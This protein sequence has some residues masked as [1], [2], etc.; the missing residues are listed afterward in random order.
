M[1]GHPLRER[2][3]R[4]LMLALYPQ[5]RHAE[6]LAAFQE[7]RAVLRD[8]LGI[9]PPAGIG[10]TRLPAELSEQARQRGATV[11]AG[12]CIDLVRAALPYFP[13]VEALQ[14]LRGTAALGGLRELSRLLR[15]YCA[16]PCV[17][18]C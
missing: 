4:Q 3:R 16:D 7:L 14:P 5:G 11:L 9:E 12:R 1:A 10:K 8:E 15:E 13:I 18:S 2:R 6:A 17:S